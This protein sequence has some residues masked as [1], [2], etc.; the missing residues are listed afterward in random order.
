[1][2]RV[3][4]IERRRFTHIFDFASCRFY[5]SAQMRDLVHFVCFKIFRRFYCIVIVDENETGYN[6][7]AR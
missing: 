1:M 7:N 5:E 2:L 4:G 3:V 6:D